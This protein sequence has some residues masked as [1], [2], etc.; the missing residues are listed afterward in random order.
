M[1]NEAKERRS[2][3]P[4]IKLR[5][6]IMRFT[7]PILVGTASFKVQDGARLKA[8][9]EPFMKKIQNILDKVDIQIKKYVEIGKKTVGGQKTRPKKEIKISNKPALNTKKIEP[10]KK[11]EPIFNQRDKMNKEFIESK[12]I[13]DSKLRELY[14]KD[15]QQ[16][17]EFKKLYKKKL[18]AIAE[19][20]SKSGGQSKT[21]ELKKMRTPW[22]Q[23]WVEGDEAF[24]TFLSRYDKYPL[25]KNKDNFIEYLKTIAK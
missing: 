15:G 18:N 4:F 20:R 5:D 23:A 25:T 13:F 22:L 24:K 2:R 19:Y 10:K 14:K 17:P 6:R 12:N 16:T 11:D 1:F 8:L 21:T 7:G 9:K 3:D